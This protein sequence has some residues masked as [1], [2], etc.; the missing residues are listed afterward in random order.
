MIPAMRERG[1][2]VGFAAAVTAASGTLG[3]ILPPSVVM[4]MYG[5]I[6]GTSI[7]GLF[8]AGILPGLLLGFAFMVTAYVVGVRN[9]FP[10]S[11]QRFVLSTF[12]VNVW[13]A[14]PALLMPLVVIG[15]LVG[16]FAT[17]TEASFVA[18][19]WAMLVA[20][21]IYRELTWK[22]LMQVSLETLRTSGAIMIIMAVAVPFAWLLTVAQVPNTVANGLLGAVADPTLKVAVILLILL[23]VGLWLDTG[24]AL[25][26]LAP[27]VHPIAVKMGL[28]PYQ[29]GLIF[30]VGLGIGLFTPPV[31]TNL[32]V[33]CNVAK[34]D[35]WTVT[36]AIVPFWVSSVIVLIM[37]A[38]IP[39]LTT[40]I[41]SYFNF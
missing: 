24:P 33:V 14:L 28:D 19:V 41:P 10:K 23:F 5:V 13:K 26:I 12:L 27:I 25:V 4:I 38:Y 36:R 15:A 1:Y 31:G 32:F 21:F 7:G 20:V 34:I 30:T 29:I 3:I 6:T 11:G 22:G 18:V 40:F 9:G 35:L 17:V 16:G 39:A 37:I 8:A 2:P